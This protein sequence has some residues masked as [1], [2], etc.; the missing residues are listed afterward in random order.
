MLDRNTFEVLRYLDKHSGRMPL[1][2]FQKKFSHLKNPS[3]SEIEHWLRKHAF[4]SYSD[5][6]EDEWGNQVNPKTIVL[7]LKGKQVFTEHLSGHTKDKFAR[8]TSILALLISLAS[9]ILT[10]VKS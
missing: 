5:Y 6:E 1:K 7:T 10:Y 2:S 9:I 4:I 3:L 8:V